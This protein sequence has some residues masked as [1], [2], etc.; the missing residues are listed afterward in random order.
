MKII[1][2]QIIT[3]EKMKN[4]YRKTEK[5]IRKKKRKITSNQSSELQ[6]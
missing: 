1:Q 3:A 6:M 5:K 2:R 4:N